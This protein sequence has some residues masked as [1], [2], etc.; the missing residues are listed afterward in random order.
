M[1]RKVPDASAHR[2]QARDADGYCTFSVTVAECTKLPEVALT[3]IV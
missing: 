3:V 1:M 2:K